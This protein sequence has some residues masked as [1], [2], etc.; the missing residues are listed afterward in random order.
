MPHTVFAIGAHPDDIEFMM[1]GTLI[2]LKQAGCQI[3]CMNI[4]DGN[5]GTTRY[6]SDEIARIRL[7]EAQDACALIGAHHHPPLCRDI[8]IFYTNDLLHRLGSVVREVA[9]D[10]LLLQSPG[11]YMED[12]MISV[13]LAVTAAFCRGMKNFPVVPA[14]PPVMNAVTVYHALPYGL[15][16][17]MRRKIASEFFVDIGGVIDTKT[18]MLACHQSQKKWLDKS[19]GL[20]SYLKTMQEMSAEVGKMSGKFAYAEGWRRHNH[21]G[22]CKPDDHPLA[23]VLDKGIYPDLS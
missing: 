8:E 14:V 6:E 16:D 2:L 7:K 21:L 1:G 17:G 18:E 5:C 19:Q 12:H 3:H 23:A 4:A 22:F 20:D 15:H 13:R 10:I 9:P 11:D